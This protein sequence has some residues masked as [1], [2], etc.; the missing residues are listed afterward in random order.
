MKSISLY[1]DLSTPIH[2]IDPMSK[3]L[4]IVTVL[5]LPVIWGSKW[6]TIGCIVFSIGILGVGCVIKKTMPIIGCSVIV[7]L[8]V[9]LIQG[10]FRAENITPIFNIG[11]LI[12][13][14]EGLVF[15]AGVGVNVINMLLAFSVLILTTK[16]SDLVEALVRKGLSP[17][18]GY[19][20][21]SVFQIIPQMSA[22]MATITDAQRSRGMET[23]GNLLTRIKAFIPL[24]GPVVMNSLISTRERA[25][26]LE[27]RGFNS[28][29]KKS[30]LNSYKPT[31]VDGIIKI[32]LL[33]FILLS[34]I[35]RILIWQHLL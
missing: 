22:T 19:V 20:L 7:I 26:A 30:F 3:L 9:V 27:V 23:E 31:K 18:I 2:H 1:E 14:K 4:Y 25:I 11:G 21:S 29:R 12:F 35:G 34:V 8:T 6:V 28:E 24:I 15:A 10:L 17:K 32:V 16:P 5:L 13:Y 33:C